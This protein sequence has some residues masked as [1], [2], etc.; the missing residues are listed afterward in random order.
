MSEGVGGQD[1]LCMSESV[2][3][4]ALALC[5][6]RVRGWGTETAVVLLKMICVKVV[7]LQQ[8]LAEDERLH[9]LSSTFS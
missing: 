8:L 7:L 4:F 3:M 5:E 6:C 9:M 2:S 1:L